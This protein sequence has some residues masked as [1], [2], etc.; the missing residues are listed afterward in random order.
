NSYKRTRCDTSALTLDRLKITLPVWY[1][2]GNFS[3]SAGSGPQTVISQR[4]KDETVAVLRSL[5]RSPWGLSALLLIGT[6]LLYGPM[7]R[8]EFI[9][10]DD[11]LYVTEN[12]VV[13]HGLTLNGVKWAFTT[14][15]AA[16]WHPV[17]WL[18]HM[19]DVELFGVDPAAHH[20][21]NVFLHSLN[22]AL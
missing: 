11:Q 7:S 19:L 17:T 6:L 1:A 5:A 8:Y 4:S 20:Y 22:A 2:A 3:M 12:Y 13:Q 14:F 10:Y 15:R 18:S 9:N 16:N 21:V